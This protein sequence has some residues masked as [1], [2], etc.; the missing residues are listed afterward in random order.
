MFT[1]LIESESHRED[2]KRKVSFFAYTL[3]GYAV[4]IFLAGVASIYAYDARLE[5][6]NLE[7]LILVAPPMEQ[8]PQRAEAS[9]PA[10]SAGDN[11]RLP[12]REVLIDRVSESTNAPA[13]VSAV[14][15]TTPEM[16]PGPVALTGRNVD[17]SPLGNANGPFIPGSRPNGKGN[18]PIVKVEGNEPPPI[19]TAPTPPAPKK[20]T[21]SKGVINSQALSLPKPPYPAAARA[22]H[23]S[24]TVTVQILLDEQGRVI[25]ARAVAG[26]PLLQAAAVKAAYQARFSPTI[27]SGEPVKVSGMITYNFMA[28]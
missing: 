17:V 13:T 7:F 18:G 22:I 9:R 27:L 19:R 26:H 6:Q 20:Q 5:S 15:P 10:A 1:N 3:A 11:N 23:A 24:G 16:P 4:L 14:G 12:E 25:S 8:P 21:I 28:Q 2:Y